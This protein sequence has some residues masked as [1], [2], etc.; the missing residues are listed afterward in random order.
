M[1]VRIFGNKAMNPC[2]CGYYGSA[3]P[4]HHCRCT[5]DQIQRYRQKISG[6][7]LDRIDLQVAVNAVPID[8]I[9]KQ[10]NNVESSAEI[11]QR[12]LQAY[13]R[14]ICRQGKLNSQ[15]KGQALKKIIPLTQ[16]QKIFMNTVFE[17]KG[18]SLRAYDRLIKVARTIA[19]IDG[20]DHIQQSHLAEALAL[21][22]FDQN[23]I[24]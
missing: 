3:L 5:P 23:F 13:E 1:G 6:P 15:L 8:T 21:R 9:Y 18:L 7:L 17:Q 4:Q 19:D 12:V 20:E 16:E 14:Q 24:S 10:E 2:P 22:Q 11:R